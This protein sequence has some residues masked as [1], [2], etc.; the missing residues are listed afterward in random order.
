MINGDSLEYNLLAK[1]VD[2]LDVVSKDFIT[3]VEIGVREG[4]GSHVICEVIKGPH[5]HIGIDPWGDIQYKHLDG[6]EGYLEYWKDEQGN[7]MK[8]PDGSFRSPTYPN[9]MKETF[10]KEFQYHTK[11]VLFQLEDT[12]YMNAFGNGVPIYY[13]G[14]KKIVNNYDL[15]F[16]D[17]PHTTEAVMREATWFAARSR[18]GTR[19]IFD[20]IDT[21]RMDLIAHAL[22]FDGFKTIETGECKICLEKQT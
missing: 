7:M 13:N 11:T 18:K 20:D 19:F 6:K 9:T 12:E 21:Y 1:W 15:V 5:I 4:Y 10:N 8:N 22:T 3:T 14:K 17:G 2:Q 16:F